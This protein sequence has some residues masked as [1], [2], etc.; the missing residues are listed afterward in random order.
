MLPGIELDRRTRRGGMAYQK[1]KR[2][3][4]VEAVDMVTMSAMS[5]KDYEDY[6]ADGLL[7]VDHHSVLRSTAAG[8]PL[9]TSKK[10]LRVL[11]DRLK[12]LE[13]NLPD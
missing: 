8:Y 2:I 9:A 3:V 12:A 4:V 11:I 10:Q 6:L 5:P 13:P 1:Q 7:E